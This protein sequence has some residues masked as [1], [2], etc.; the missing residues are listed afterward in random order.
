MQFNLKKN[1]SMQPNKKNETNGIHLFKHNA[2][3]LV[4]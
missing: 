1:D 4:E 2:I 3:H